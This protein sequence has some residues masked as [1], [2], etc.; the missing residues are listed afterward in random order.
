MTS[1]VRRCPIFCLLALTACGTQEIVPTRSYDGTPGDDKGGLLI[2]F[3]PGADTFE[4]QLARASNG[5]LYLTPL[6]VF[7][8]GRQLVDAIGQ[9]SGVYEASTV[10]LGYLPAG[11]H[12]LMIG[13]AGGSSI[14]AGDIAIAP[15][16]ANRL[17]LFAHQGAIQS[18][19]ISYPATPAPGTL[20]VSVLD[21]VRAGPAIEVVRCTDATSCALV[22]APLAIG[23]SFEADF[24]AAS[25]DFTS[26]EPFL[27]ADGSWLGYRQAASAAQPVPPVLDLMPGDQYPASWTEG[28]DPQTGRIKPVLNLLAVPIYMSPEGN[29]VQSFD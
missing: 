1:S 25:V 4:G 20:H 12:H 10:G 24:P 19:F 6:L 27:L 3:A 9:P 11:T 17:F 21:L 8:D 29:G 18:R 23:E 28:V 26:R 5:N 15:R 16:S 13:E 22:S 7:V 2:S 14:F